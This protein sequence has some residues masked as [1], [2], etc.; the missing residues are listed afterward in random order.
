MGF[1][2][3]I[4]K[5]VGKLPAKRQTLFFSATMP[6]EIEE[7]AGRMLHDPARVAVTPVASTAE[8]IA[9][10]VMHVEKNRKSSLLA[11]V[12]RSEPIDRALVFTRTK[13]GADRVVRHLVK[14]GLP[15]E[16]IHGNKSQGQRERALSSFRQ[17]G[18]RILIATDIAARGID[19]DGISHVV[20][21]D[22]P[23]V[24]ETYVH[25]IGRTA[26]AGAE[27]VAIS[28]C[29]PEERAFLR[30]IEKLTRMAIPAENSATLGA[31]ATTRAPDSRPREHRFRNGSSSRPDG[32]KP[33]AA[34]AKNRHRRRPAQE[35]P[36]QSPHSQSEIAQVGFMRSRHARNTDAQDRS[37]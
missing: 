14:A 3:D 7:L 24:P 11:D 35:R 5:I 30:A 13:H 33:H 25:R 37:R 21:F 15:A 22:I 1:I 32:A 12:L 34:K 19:V 28:F 36:A 29:D 26:R 9:Q 10:R 16:A 31:D 8:R 18:I 20:N 17:G 6:R 4:R 23:N 27:G 2:N